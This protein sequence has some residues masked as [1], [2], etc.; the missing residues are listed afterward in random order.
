M[1]GGG[2]V[3]RLLGA[4]D[5][6]GG[7]GASGGCEAVGGPEMRGI[8]D[9]I[10]L[11]GCGGIVTIG[12]GGSEVAPRRDGGKDAAVWMSIIG[13]PSITPDSIPAWNAAPRA[14]EPS[15]SNIREAMSPIVSVIL[16]R[17]LSIRDI[18]PVA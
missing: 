18:P 8:C 15:G 1:P 10:V 16:F 12:G 17:T 5:P 7:C 9:D 2:V 14:T 11:P 3:D 4:S 6:R 13:I